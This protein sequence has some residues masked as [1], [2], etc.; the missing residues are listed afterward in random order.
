[1][2]GAKLLDAIWEEVLR[3]VVFPKW[4]A[5]VSA[6]FTVHSYA[7]WLREVTTYLGIESPE[8]ECGKSTL[9]TVLSRLVDRPA[10]S[11]NISSSAFF[12]VIEELQP[13]LLIDEAD[14]NLRGNNDLAGILNA[15]YTKS[16]GFVWRMCYGPGGEG[17][18]GASPEGG[19]G[20]PAR[21]SC[22][23]PKA[24]AAI[25]SLP[26]I[27]AS[28][29]IV[30]RMHRKMAGEECE[31]L[32]HLKE[33]E[34]KRKCARFVADHAEEIA[35]AE[36]KMPAGLT[37]RAA[38]IWEPLLV[39]AD[40]AGGR[41]PELSR[42]AAVGLTAQAH[43][44]SPIGS[45]L[46]DIF[47]VFAEGKTDRVFSRELLEV[48]DS[49]GE[50]PW[51]ELRRGKAMTEAWLAQQ[52]RPYGIRPRTIRIGERVGR[53]YLQEDMI[54]TFRRYIPKS[55]IER[56]KAELDER[57]V[58]KDEAKTDVE[59]GAAVEGNII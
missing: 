42:Q 2:D 58:P 45:L 30:M 35:K 43:E 13:T 53:G 20:W 4:G 7:F 25:G 5:E 34:L 23:C 56:L 1:V 33:E 29:C 40:L 32:K 54:E 51:I 55:E 22:W 57:R 10:V 49:W 47:L 52:L 9:L 18:E 11:A 8:K 38:D 59:G 15:G 12:R 46:L 19:T 41:W 16:T 37:N 36:P 28:R 17:A 24:I 26:P 48:L 50:R 14:T 44:H 39:L 21:Y 3:F 27:L 6:L 31:R